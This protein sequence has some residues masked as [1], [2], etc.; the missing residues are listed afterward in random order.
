MPQRFAWCNNATLPAQG[1]HARCNN[2]TLPMNMVAEKGIPDGGKYVGPPSVME[3]YDEYSDHECELV[4]QS[5]DNIMQIIITFSLF[6]SPTY[7]II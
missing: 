6:C 5:S 3:L 1:G 4:S 7:I 2:A